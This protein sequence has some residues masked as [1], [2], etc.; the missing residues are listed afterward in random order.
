MLVS[1]A[2][3]L[4]ASAAEKPN[5]LFILTDDLGWGDLGVFYQNQRME[6]RRFATPMLDRMAAEGMQLRRHYVPAPV[7]APS[8]ASLLTGRHQGHEDI[9]NNQ[10][11]KALGTSHNLATVLKQSGYRTALIGKYGLP[12]GDRA[13]Y[14]MEQWTAFPTLRGFDEFFGAVKHRD[15]H[16]QYP[17]N[18]YPRGDSELHRGTFPLYHN[19]Q[20]LSKELE[21][22]YTTDLF[23]AFAKNW[24]IEHRRERGDQP[25]FMLLSHTTPHAAL[26]VPSMPYPEGGGLE[27]GIQWVGESGRMVNTVGGDF[28]GWIHPDFVD[29]DWAE[30]E[31][32]FATMV[33]RIDDTVGDLMHT[34]KDLGIDRETLIV[35]TS[36]NG[37]HH[38]SYLSDLEYNPTSFDSYG[39]FTG[40]KRDVLEGG[41]RVPTLVRWPGSIPAGAI[42]E[43]PAQFQDWLP[44]FC[45][46]AGM[47][48]PAIS[49]GVSLL[50][51]LTGAGTWRSGTVYV[52]YFNGARTPDYLEFDP[53]HRSRPRNEMQV[54]YLDGYKGL[55]TNI[56]SHA[57]DF[58]IF[59][60]AND[61]QE[62]VNLAEISGFRDDLQQRMKDR[63]LRI[64]RPNASAPRPYDDEPV[65]GI[66]AQLDPHVH[67][68]RYSGAFPWVPQTAKL[69]AMDRGSSS[70]VS[71]KG[72]GASLGDVLEFKGHI[73]ARETGSY[74]FSVDAGE[75]AIL[76][77]HDAVVVDNETEFEGQRVTQGSILLDRG[78]HP[79]TLTVLVGRKGD[80]KFEYLLQE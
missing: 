77:V 26:H 32:R 29:K 30:Q 38:E 79:F 44:T 70:S 7:C 74:Q 20:Q 22:A 80:L 2:L 12:G 18:E 66:A 46:V 6:S 58:M 49:D 4:L 40:V 61:P 45:R 31:K 24:I 19:E 27:G 53:R 57:D 17:G 11:D 59:D 34:L 36:D 56:K 5:I 37:P 67:W 72:V 73:H 14:D 15:G 21:G 48:A 13:R 1:L 16:S 50:P 68:A 76:R 62:Q 51:L 60:I 23:T 9:R 47:P 25:F 78:V 39:P 41:I 8:R 69:E 3:P 33:R 35:F 28:D 10:F 75:G 63:V 42:N 52:E 64:R 55:R 43:T 54:I 71:L 65:P